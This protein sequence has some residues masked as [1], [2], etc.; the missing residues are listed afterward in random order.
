MDAGLVLFKS[1]GDLTF[2]LVA[3]PAENEVLMSTVLSGLV[4]GV[5]LLL[6]GAVD[7]KSALENL[8]LVLLAVDEVVDRG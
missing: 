2:Y 7:K 3:G 8:D 4:E 1:L 6:R 5:A